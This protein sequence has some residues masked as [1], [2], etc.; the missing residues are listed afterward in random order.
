M[1]I[2]DKPYVSDFLI[3]TIKK[4]GFEV[5]DNETSR[6]YF[7]NHKLI[8]TQ[9]AKNS[10]K[11][12]TN[13]ENSLFW[14]S[15]NMQNSNILKMIELCKNKVL[16]RKTLSKIYPDYYFKSVKFNELKNIK[17][18]KYPLILKPSTGFLSFGVYPIKNEN[19]WN[20]VLLKIE[21]DI[22]KLQGVFPLCVVDTGN[23]IIEELIEGREFALD[24]YFDEKGEAII[25]NI[26]EHPF[27]DDKDVSDRAYYTNKMIFN[28]F[29]DKFLELLNK[30]GKIGNFKNFPFHIELRANQNAIIPIEI[31]PL[32]F[33][34]WCITDIAQNA[35]GI[36]VYEY[37]FKNKK[38]DW[39]NILKKADDDYFY[40][41]IGENPKGKFND[42]NYN[43]Y[44][45]N[46]SNPLVIRKIDYKNNPI[47]A[48][49]FAKTKSI[50]EIKNILKLDM[51]EFKI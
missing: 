24:A 13:S 30:I 5:L 37:Y 9:S 36:N 48:I 42:I 28:K 11:F 6:K 22:E 4:E 34:G 17:P 23:F 8:K 43:A 21:K 7:S 25:L 51:N 49:V 20:S 39:E 40:F 15:E 45:K 14:F 46:I 3:E 32:R 27:F 47:F 33:C 31:N 26:F 50:D 12:Y 35:W 38:P 19:E 18:E 16:F 29:Y 1:I 2:L 44:L 10:E 41:T